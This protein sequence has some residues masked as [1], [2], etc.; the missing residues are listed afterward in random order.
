MRFFR[1]ISFLAALPLG[2]FAETSEQEIQAEPLLPEFRL[3][4]PEI[5]KLD[6]GVRSL[7][8]A[9]INGNGLIDIAVINNNRSRI[10]FLYQVG[11]DDRSTP[12]AQRGASEGWRPTLEDQRLSHKHIITGVTMFDLAVADL[13]GDGH[14]DLVYTNRQEG[15]TIRYQGED[16]RFQEV[17]N[18]SIESPLS[19]GRTVRVEDLNDD[20]Q[21]EVV[22]LTRRNLYL[23]AQNED[24]E[25]RDPVIYPLPEENNHALSFW[26]LEGNGLLDIL[27]FVPNHREPF[28]VR[29]QIEPLVFGPELSFPMSQPRTSPGFLPGD[30]E[31]TLLQI[32]SL[33]DESGLI[34]KLRFGRGP[35]RADR[36]FPTLRPLSFTVPVSGSQSPSYLSGYFTGEDTRD[37][38]V[39][40]PGGARIL[41]YKQLPEGGFASPEI[42]PSLADIRAMTKGTFEPEGKEQIVV[43]SFREETVGLTSFNESGRLDFPSPLP[44]EGRPTTLAV[45]RFPGDAF[46]TL[47]VTSQKD[48]NLRELIFLQKPNGEW[49]KTSFPIEG[50][51]ADP[52]G[53][54]VLD[55]NGD[56]QLEIAIFVPFS[57]LKLYRKDEEDGWDDVSAKANYRPSLVDR[58]E[59]IQ[60]TLADVN[61]DGHQEMVVARGEFARGLLLNEEG[62][63]EIVDQLNARSHDNEITLTF[64]FDLNDDGEEEMLLFDQSRGALQVLQ[65]GAEGVFRF[66]EEFSVGSIEVVDFEITDLN[67]NGVPDILLYGKDRF[68]WIPRDPAPFH[69]EQLFVYESDI[70]DLTY[71]H[72][73]TGDMNHDG[74]LDLVTLDGRNTRILEILARQENDVQSAFHFKLFEQSPHF[75]GRSG[76]SVEPREIRIADLNGNGKD[77]ILL[78]VHDRLL[79]YPQKP[80]P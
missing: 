28:R 15:L 59:K 7:T 61:Q 69:L 47:M 20:G 62:S 30:G 71:T 22:V 50:I 74:N 1:T 43:A 17:R 25:Y 48:R 9:D 42:F 63:L 31:D 53:L 35:E 12:P 21:K 11:E 49:E 65:R 10:E 37:L 73:K 52:Q 5:Y 3:G 66:R 60:L 2:A 18:L 57:P 70:D 44:V 14:G 40:D 68:W 64:P 16:R 13:N 76:A 27:Y 78:L 36:D 29:R 32:Y 72:L 77:D 51:R 79:I 46:D 41:H 67:D 45:T 34:E 23:F 19:H 58:L 24:H 26:D 75:Q 38:L 4:G 39:A 55:A 6:W 56:G 8:S 80:L 54:K 33:Q